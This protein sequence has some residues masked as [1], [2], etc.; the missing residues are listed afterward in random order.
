MTVSVFPLGPGSRCTHAVKLDSDG[1]PIALCGKPATQDCEGIPLCPKHQRDWISPL[2]AH[3]DS[4][5]DSG[6]ATYSEVKA[7]RRKVRRASR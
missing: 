7:F 4:P 3:R 2:A 5:A 1:R 6:P